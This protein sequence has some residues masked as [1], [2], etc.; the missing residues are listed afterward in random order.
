[1]TLDEPARHRLRLPI[2]PGRTGTGVGL[3]A[4]FADLLAGSAAR[5]ETAALLTDPERTET[6][7]WQISDDLGLV[8]VVD[9]LPPPIPDPLVSGEVLAVDA[10]AKVA[11]V[12]GEPLF[13]LALAGLPPRLPD[14]LL[15]AL[16]RGADRVLA[17]AGA[18][19]AGGQAIE[20]ATP[21]FALAVVGRLDPSSRLRP[22]GARPGDRLVL[23][24]PL[25]TG[26]VLAGQ[27]RREMRETWL[28]A[29]VEVMTRLDAPAA[30][31]ARRHRLAG[32][33]HVG[34]SGFLGAAAA[35]ARAARCRVV[36]EA[37]ELPALP[38]AYELA[39][40]GVEDEGAVRIRDAVAPLLTLDLRLDPLLVA[41]A[42]DPQTA[43][44]L[45]LAVP[46]TRLEPVLRE[47]AATGTRPWVVGRVEAAARPEVVLG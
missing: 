1:M 44:G 24:K 28:A 15:R 5:A 43:G 46:P 12:G 8:A 10:L 9:A 25:G 30:E 21:V 41:L 40:A 29:A 26:L 16:L 33:V 22:D 3:E 19:L 32:C 14:T 34:R 39:A 2:E 13:A 37:R 38:G 20:S 17:R 36:L 6:A 4:V 18:A 47:L 27:G 42:A 11:A 7:L 45:L 35:T 23:T 31:V